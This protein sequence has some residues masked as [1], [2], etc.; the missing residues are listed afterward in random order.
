MDCYNCSE[1]IEL[2]L[3]VEEELDIEEQMKGKAV[4]IC[5]DCW[6][7]VDPDIKQVLP[8]PNP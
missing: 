7:E 5:I 8:D 2:G 4:L 3:T 1:E 6:S